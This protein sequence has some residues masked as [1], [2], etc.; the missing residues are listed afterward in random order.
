MKMPSII[1]NPGAYK[2][3]FVYMGMF[4]LVVAN[5]FLGLGIDE[6]VYTEKLKELVNIVIMII[7][8]WGVWGARNDPE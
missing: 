4:A 2:K 7:G 8:G 3:L 6:D 1:T 5:E